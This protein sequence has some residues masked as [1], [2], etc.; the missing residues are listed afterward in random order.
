MKRIIL[1]TL[2]LIFLSGCWDSKDLEKQAFVLA[3]GIDKGPDGMIKVTYLIP[4][5]EFGSQAQGGG[6]SVPKREI[7]TMEAND[8]VSMKNRANTV[9]AKTITYDQLQFIAVSEAF[10]KEKDFLAFIYDATKDVEIRRDVNL[11]VT[12]QQPEDYFKNNHPQLEIRSHKYFELM[13]EQTAA[14]TGLI[15]SH[16]ELLNYFRITEEGSDLFMAI[17]SSLK[18]DN[19]T[20]NKNNILAGDIKYGGETNSIQFAGSALFKNGKMIGK[21]NGQETRIARLLNNT[22]TNIE[23]I[24]SYTDPFDPNKQIAVKIN[25]TKPNKIRMNLETNPGII[26]IKVPLVFEILANHSMIDYRKKENRL[27]LEKHLSQTIHKEMMKF[28]NKTQTEFEAAPF[29]WSLE[30]RKKFMTIQKY[31]AYN[32]PGKYKNME[33]RLSIDTSIQNF[34]RQGSNI[35]PR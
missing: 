6:E 13:I 18:G 20:N 12:E 17:Y 15:P 16:S 27:K 34:G 22:Q 32:F 28:I 21:I 33:I 14:D 3:I 5:P 25:K 24:E 4:N 30:A 31:E 19:N 11:V 2:S 10:A 29:A 8:F 23:A 26:E 9:I 35:K 1:I 7:I